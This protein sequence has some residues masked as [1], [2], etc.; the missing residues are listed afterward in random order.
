MWKVYKH[1]G[2]Y[3]MGELISS[4]KSESAAMKKAEKKI[5]FK[6]TEREKKKNE[7]RIWL[8]DHNHS[9]VGVIF[10]KKDKGV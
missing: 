8:D 3:I 9:P 1:N 5:K 7:I 6:F 2:Q 10:Q 4:H